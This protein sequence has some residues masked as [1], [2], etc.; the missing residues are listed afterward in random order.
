MTFSR[1]TQW[2][3]STFSTATAGSCVEVGAAPGE[4]AVRDTKLGSASPMLV[5]SS[6]NWRTFVRS[7][8][9]TASE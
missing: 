1:F 7:A 3:V 4:R 6:E 9:S 5:F 8:A 2:H